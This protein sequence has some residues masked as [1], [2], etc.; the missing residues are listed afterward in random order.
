M[1]CTAGVDLRSVVSE[2]LFSPQ[3]TVCNDKTDLSKHVFVITSFKLASSLPEISYFWAKK[4]LMH[5]NLFS[6]VCY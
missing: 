6:V 4:S 2:D 5:C 3:L 1:H